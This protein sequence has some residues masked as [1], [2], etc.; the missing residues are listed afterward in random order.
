VPIRRGVVG[1]PASGV[2]KSIVSR[3]LFRL[4]AELAFSF[5]RVRPRG[6][7]LTEAGVRSAST[8]ARVCAEIDIALE[9]IMPAA[10]CAAASGSRRRY[11]WDRHILA[12]AFAEMARRHPLLHLQASYSDRSSEFI[13]EGFDCAIRV[14]YLSDST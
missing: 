12:P 7:A 11:P 2:S 10:N 8:A 3:R 9:T 14:C 1:C 4:E 13:G 5:S 6:A